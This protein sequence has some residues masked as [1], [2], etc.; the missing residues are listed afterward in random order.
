MALS[1]SSRFI[2]ALAAA[3]WLLWLSAAHADNRGPDWAQ[4]SPSQQQ[5]LA[6]LKDDWVNIEGP[7]RH[8]WVEI[9]KRYGSMTPAQQARLQTRMRQWA[10][11]SVEERAQVRERYKRLQE[12]PPE[13]R[14]EIRRKWHEYDSLTEEEKDTLRQAHPTKPAGKP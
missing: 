4:L 14:E 5:V 6:P 13:K 10:S 8:K 9:A 1:R 12:M 2:Q 3:A 7:R 11:L